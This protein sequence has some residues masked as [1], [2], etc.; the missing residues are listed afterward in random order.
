MRFGKCITVIGSNCKNDYSK[1]AVYQNTNFNH[2]LK[3]HTLYVIKKKKSET[4]TLEAAP[5][6]RLMNGPTHG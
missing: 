2:K 3:Q 1:E 5:F 4:P 6:K